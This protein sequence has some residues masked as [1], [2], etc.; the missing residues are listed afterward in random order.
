MLWLVIRIWGFGLFEDLFYDFRTWGLVRD[1]SC[2]F[3]L[4]L[5]V[6]QLRRLMLQT[7]RF[8]CYEVRAV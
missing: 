7:L 4:L 1:C 3:T 2:C 6:Y 8:V 5:Q